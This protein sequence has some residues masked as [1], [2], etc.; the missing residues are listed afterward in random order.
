MP[1]STLSIVGAQP[2]TEIHVEEFGCVEQAMREAVLKEWSRLTHV[3]VV[4]A[5]AQ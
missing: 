1:D 2:S 5:N 4:V 3:A